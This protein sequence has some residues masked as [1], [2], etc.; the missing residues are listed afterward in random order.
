[1]L[2][3]LRS[4]NLS[5]ITLAA[6]AV[7]LGLVSLLAVW[8][9]NHA[10]LVDFCDY[11]LVMSAVGRINLGERPYVDFLTPIQTLPFF[12][13]WIAE[14]IGGA[15]YLSL[16]YANAVFLAASYVILLSILWRRLGPVLAWLVST[17][18]VAASACQHTIVWYNAV[19]TLW[20]AIVS[21]LTSQPWKVDTRGILRVSAV[22]LVLWLSGMT[23]LT[24]HIAAL[25]FAA[26]FTFRCAVLHQIS[27]QQA[28]RAMLL[29]TLF[30]VVAPVGTELLLTG[31]TLDQW[32]YNVIALPARFRTG[33]LG[34]IKTATF[35]FHTPHD[36]YK[37]LRFTFVGAWGVVLLLGVGCVIAYSIFRRSSRRGVELALLAVPLGGA[38]L[39]GS[40]LLATNMDI[41]YVSAASWLVFAVALVLA[42]TE[43]QS[44]R[45]GNVA[46]AI[47]AVGSVTLLVPALQSAWH[48]TR[49]LWGHEPMVRSEL[50]PAAGLP[51]RFAYVKG[52]LLTRP[53]YESLE[54]FEVLQRTLSE[55]GVPNSAYYFVNATD[56]MVRVVPEARHA[57]LP[58]WLAGGTTLSPEDAWAV[59]DWLERSKDVDVILSHEAW[60]Y[61]YPGM[62]QALDANFRT[63]RAGLRLITYVRE[64]KPPPALEFANNTQSNLYM[65][66]MKITGR[67]PHVKLSSN[68]LFYLG[69]T[70]PYRLDFESP[71]F[72]LTGEI[73][74]ELLP[75]SQG[76]TSATFS[77]YA[78]DGDT[79]KERMVHETIELSAGQRTALKTFSISPGG[80]PVSFLLTFSSGGTANFGWRR[81]D[82]QHSGPLKPNPP[83]AV[84]SELQRKDLGQPE[85][86]A[87][88]KGDHAAV[89]ALAAYGTVN[90]LPAPVQD[91]VLL[92]APGE[93]WIRVDQ[94]VGRLTGEFVFAEPST[95]FPSANVV[96]V[97]AVYYKSGRFEIRQ[98]AELR[99]GTT[100]ADRQP[101]RFQV[102]LP[103]GI[104]W[105]GL[106][107]TVPEENRA[108]LGNILWRDL[109]LE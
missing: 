15:R 12:V 32:L 66:D 109:R 45:A 11:G 55:R 106:V 67:A 91:G 62:K 79:L 31:A 94:Q 87:L 71:L 102:N 16:T 38:W 8:W 14:R 101:H 61:W 99:P 53:M 20:I 107:V 43:S 89:G 88:F 29:Y 26:T 19:G 44:R 52:M 95:P 51:P 13:G 76:P 28:A 73:Y 3:I 70:T 82:T 54:E 18:V 57:G 6:V 41:A 25:A 5:R 9:R 80:R 85:I 100:P 60:N 47:L 36:Y 50:V 2:D 23:K 78:R 72:R 75:N 96:R 81:L 104:G 90:N 27:W 97:S 46:R 21:W 74:G 59:G 93:I 22:C 108:P 42:F 37:P 69:G 34:Q 39:C 40:V 92:A 48:G 30:G 17:A 35:Y 77:V 1:M 83:H 7:G 65:R 64:D 105:I 4:R 63:G 10:I 49:A 24:Y 56:W 86:D 68:N 84:S 58:L 33:M 103:E 98:Q